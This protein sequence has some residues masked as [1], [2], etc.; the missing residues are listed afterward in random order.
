MLTGH[1]DNAVVDEVD[2]PAAATPTDAAAAAFVLFLFPGLDHDL[3]SWPMHT[4]HGLPSGPSTVADASDTM[5][6]S[7]M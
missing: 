4:L 7:V 5:L 2:P 1:W 6:L 3:Q